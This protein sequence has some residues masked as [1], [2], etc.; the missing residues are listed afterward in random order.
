MHFS[1]M[2]DINADAV[3]HSNGRT[4]FQQGELGKPDC[5]TAAQH[6]L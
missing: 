3:L 4:R 1:F 6:V 2:Q 5:H